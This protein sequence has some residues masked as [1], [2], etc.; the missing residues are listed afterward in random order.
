[1]HAIVEIDKAGRIVIPK[2]FRDELGLRPGTQLHLAR[3]GELLQLAAT[4]N[5]PEV[6]FENGVPL[7]VPSGQHRSQIVT[8]EMVNELLDAGWND[9]TETFLNPDS[10]GKMAVAS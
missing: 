4:A 3:L 1:M 10:S 7:I 6:I 9:R 2:R 5:E 8:T